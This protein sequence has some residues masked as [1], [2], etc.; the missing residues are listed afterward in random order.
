VRL[1][2]ARRGG[3]RADAASKLY[4][5]RFGIAAHR[6]RRRAAHAAGADQQ[7]PDAL[8]VFA[9][10]AGVADADRKPVAFFDGVGDRPAAQRD[11][12]FVL[13]VLDGNA[14]TRRRFAVDV[15]LQVPLPHDRR[16][17]RVARAAER[18]ERR[19]DVLADAVDCVQIGAKHLDADVGADPGGEH[20][21][22][23]DDGLGKDVAPSRHLQHPPHLVIDEVSLGPGFSR[24][25]EDPVVERFDGIFV[26]RQK[27]LERLAAALAAEL[28]LDGLRGELLEQGAVGGSLGEFRRE[29]G[30]GNFFH[31][32]LRKGLGAAVEKLPVD[33][34][35]SLLP[36]RRA[37]LVD[38]LEQFAG[39]RPARRSQGLDKFHNQS[40]PG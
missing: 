22:A 30:L 31:G 39:E 17:D 26:D 32:V 8:F 15:N 5:R 18:F 36:E 7:P 25:E 34:V 12:D 21:D 38:G 11:F 14:I 20:F 16:G 23:V 40:G 29:S 13:D 28:P 6:G 4:G 19:L 2:A 9:L 24:P 27:G 33:T 37:A 10:R 35:D 3:D 1:V